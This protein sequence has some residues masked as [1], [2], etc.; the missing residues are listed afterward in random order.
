MSWNGSANAAKLGS[1]PAGAS[2]SIAA[3][4]QQRADC[5]GGLRRPYLRVDENVT[6]ATRPPAAS[7]RWNSNG[8]HF[9]NELVSVVVAAS[10]DARSRWRVASAVGAPP[11]PSDSRRASRSDRCR[12][13]TRRRCC[14]VAQV[15]S[16]NTSMLPSGA[17]AG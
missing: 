12:R 11:M 13:C 4:Q 17:N 8:A 2:G 16:L 9:G 7:V 5:R 3:I 14:R 1:V 15:D 10:R 6:H